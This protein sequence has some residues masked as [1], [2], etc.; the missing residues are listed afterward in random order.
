LIGLDEKPIID[1][2][3]EE[4]PSNFHPVKLEP[5]N[6]SYYEGKFDLACVKSE[7]EYGENVPIKFEKPKD[8]SVA[9]IETLETPSTEEVRK[10]LENFDSS[11]SGLISGRPRFLCTE[12]VIFDNNDVDLENF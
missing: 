9:I 2:T 1:I 5:A 10:M 3:E 6:P 4:T 12:T 11:T 7:P 8:E